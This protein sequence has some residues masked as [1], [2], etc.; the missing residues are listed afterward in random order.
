[1]TTNLF[2][3]KTNLQLQISPE[4]KTIQSR[5]IKKSFDIENQI[6]TFTNIITS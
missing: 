2:G 3:L 5:Y 4:K 1:M 6:N